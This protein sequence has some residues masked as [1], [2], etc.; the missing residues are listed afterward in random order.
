MSWEWE[1]FLSTF[2][3][4]CSSCVCVCIHILTFYLLNIF[5]ERCETNQISLYIS[6]LLS[7]CTIPNVCYLI[8]L[9]KFSS[10][11][12]DKGLNVVKM[13]GGAILSMLV[14]C[15]LQT[16][17]RQSCFIFIILS[18][19]PPLLTHYY[20]LHFLSLLFCSVKNTKKTK[21]KSDPTVFS[22]S[23]LGA[24]SVSQMLTKVPR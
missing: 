7:T 4:F 21:T 10:C 5:K 1:Y 6:L 13:H 14:F 2:F 19:W 20:S 22:D 8:L 3:V 16:V 12:I 11:Q 17:K 15:L 18:L 9:G 24:F 23:G